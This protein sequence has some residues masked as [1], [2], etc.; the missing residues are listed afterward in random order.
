MSRK[1]WDKLWMNPEPARAGRTVH[2][3]TGFPEP[4]IPRDATSQCVEA[5]REN[6]LSRF[7]AVS[8]QL[9]TSQR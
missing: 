2:R 4:A 9:L 7:R 6:E 8:Y 3:L 5:E 1:P